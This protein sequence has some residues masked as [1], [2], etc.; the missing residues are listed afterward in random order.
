MRAAKIN[1]VSA[2]VL[3]GGKSTRA[4]M[5]KQTIRINGTL[6]A[7]RIADELASVFREVILVTNHPAFYASTRHR[8]IEDVFHEAGPLG[9]IHAGL[10]AA[11]AERVFVTACDMPNIDL[12]FVRWVSRM[13]KKQANRC[14]V[15]ALKLDNGMFEPMNAVY[16]RRCLP[17]ITQ[18]L[19][20]NNRKLGNLLTATRTH[21]LTEAQ[22]ARFG[23][24]ERL[25]FNMNTPLEIQHYLAKVEIN[26]PVNAENARLLPGDRIQTTM[27]MI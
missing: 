3:C 2:V 6:I 9:G 23:G 13:A 14:D 24:T 10:S 22:L 16:S 18:M 21:F 17:C 15:I 20:E 4:G 25:F 12:P 1:G 11:T 26:C 27:K 7:E 8:V 5:D 19:E